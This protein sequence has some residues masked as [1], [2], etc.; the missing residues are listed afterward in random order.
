MSTSAA[1]DEDVTDGAGAGIGET[2]GSRGKTAVLFG[3]SIGAEAACGGVAPGWADRLVDLSP[4]VTAHPPKK[5]LKAMAIAI[6]ETSRSRNIN[7][8]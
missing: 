2:L 4:D 5:R 7:Q 1:E 8:S 6:T 3:T